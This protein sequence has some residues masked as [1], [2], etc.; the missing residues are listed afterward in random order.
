MT[1]YTPSNLQLKMARSILDHITRHGLEAGSHV[2]EQ[3][4]AEEFQVSRSPIRGALL[5]LLEKGVVVQ[6]ENRG[7]FIA[8][9]GHE[10]LPSDLSLPKTEEEELCVSIAKDWFEKKAPQSF[11][12]AA[13]RRRY[14]LGRLVASRILLRLSEEGVISRNPG[15]GWQ[16][17]P[18]LNTQRAHDDSY[19]FRLALEPAA[20]LAPS[21]ALDKGLAE[22]S[23]RR[24]ETALEVA[25]EDA[26]LGRLF[27]IDA[28]FHQLIGIS[29]HNSFFQ[30]AIERQN[31]LRR[32]VEYESLLDK[33]RFVQSCA[34]HMRILDALENGQQRSA[35]DLMRRHLQI[36]SEVG[37]EYQAEDPR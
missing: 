31:S 24:H 17:E 26:P 14:N 16:F 29:S 36:A 37:P 13:F 32:L 30:A 15:H 4:L 23:R 25:P 7:F 6:R 28:E 9:D 10:L 20:I 8:L 3:E 21:F 1:D 5:F 2:T 35:A 33:S 34:E 12:E 27:D 22:I 18:T 19:A 11:S